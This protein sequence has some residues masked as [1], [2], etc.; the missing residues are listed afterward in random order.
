V[1]FLWVRALG[2]KDWLIASALS[3]ILGGTIGNL[4]D[5]LVYRYVIDF[6][7]VVLWSWHFLDFNIGDAQSLRRY[8]CWYSTRFADE[9]SILT[10]NT[11]YGGECA[12]RY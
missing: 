2:K 7:D 8:V 9:R 12:V 3:L 1:I 11:P 4:A 6:I 5:R 10:A